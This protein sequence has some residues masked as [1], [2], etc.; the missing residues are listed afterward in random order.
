MM[1]TDARLAYT[2]WAAVV[3][4]VAAVLEAIHTR[5]LRH[6]LHHPEGHSQAHI[7]GHRPLE[8]IASPTSHVQHPQR[9]GQILQEI[10]K[11]HSRHGR[12]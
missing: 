3:G 7:K 9:N 1:Q 5:Q 12:I 2:P 10:V 4:Q 6:T 8:Q 11:M